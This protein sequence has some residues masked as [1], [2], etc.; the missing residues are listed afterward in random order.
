MQMDEIVIDQDQKTKEKVYSM[1]SIWVGTFLGGPLTTGY[2]AAENFKALGQADKVKP[3]WTIAIIATVIVFGGVLMIPN[4]EKVPT[5]L[6]PLFYTAIAYVVVNNLQGNKIKQYIE[7]TGQV[8][9]GWRSAGIGLICAV[10]SIAPIFMYVFATDPILTAGSKTY[11]DLNHEVYFDVN[12]ISNAE[13][14]EVAN[15]LTQAEFFD[16]EQQ[17][18]VFLQKDE[19]G[20]AI[21]IPLIEGA[22]NDNDVV[23]YYESL[24][25]EVQRSIT[26]KAVIINLCDDEDV[27]VVHK[28]LR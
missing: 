18:A 3:T 10:I 24:R 9:S 12:T 14:D 17:K 19:S 1:R 22:W 16:R 5:H 20:Y 15:A 27:S 26:G 23:S 11:G 13:V 21:S 25:Q 8:F 28:S 7:E 4:V 6:I 2:L